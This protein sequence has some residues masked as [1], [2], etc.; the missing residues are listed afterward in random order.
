MELLIYLVL[1]FVV[2]PWLWRA[3]WSWGWPVLV[4]FPLHAAIAYV[5]RC[6]LE[7]IGLN[8]YRRFF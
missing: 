8:Q 4:I 6:M 5:G 2:L 3:P 7:A 1:G